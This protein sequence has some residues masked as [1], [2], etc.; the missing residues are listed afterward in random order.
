MVDGSTTKS[1]EMVYLLNYFILF[2]G[3]IQNNTHVVHLHLL[4]SQRLI[5]FTVNGIIS[6]LFHLNLWLFMSQIRICEEEENPCY[7]PLY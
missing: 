6:L 5:R 2:Y 1:V 3:N 7:D 4:Y